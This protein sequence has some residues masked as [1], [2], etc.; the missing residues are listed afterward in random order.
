[1]SA[2]GSSGEHVC[3]MGREHRASRRAGVWVGLE[4]LSKVFARL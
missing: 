1:M 4:E 2:D 3:G